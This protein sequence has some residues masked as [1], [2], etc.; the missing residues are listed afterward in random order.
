VMMAAIGLPSPRRPLSAALL[1][2]P[3]PEGRG[4]G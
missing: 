2:L 1:T 3:S 4:R